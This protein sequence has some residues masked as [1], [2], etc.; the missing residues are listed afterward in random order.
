MN[1]MMMVA[2]AAL[3]S[4]A[5][6]A[7]EPAEGAKRPERRM[8][9]PPMGERAMMGGAGMMG[10]P[11]AWAVMNPRVAEKI[12]LSD[13]QK[14]KLKEL[15]GARGGNRELQEKV[16]KGME[17]Q[18]ELLKAEK[19]DEAAVMAA[20]DEVFEARKTVA[21]EQ[22]KRLIAIRAILTPEQAA[23]AT[24]AM[25]ELRGNRGPRGEGRGPRGP[26]P[27]APKS[28]APK[29]DAQPQA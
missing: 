20:I 6:F 17:K 21:K 2:V 10:D 4:A 27:E 25:K 23:K 29:A 7:D 5:C 18:M 19:I 13:E 16:R 14:A 3:V 1:K 11:I 24:E 26:K 28:E 8:N 12:G 22:T 15:Q 9:R